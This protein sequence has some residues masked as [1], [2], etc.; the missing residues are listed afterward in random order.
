M[1]KV[2][3]KGYDGCKYDKDSSKKWEQQWTI[4]GFEVQTIPP[5]E[6]LKD[7]DEEML[8]EYNEYLVLHCTDGDTAT[9]RNSH[10][11]LF[12]IY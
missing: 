10:V 3:I 4:E 5:E 6:F 12:R 11:D 8:D 7:A 2:I 1:F 9:F